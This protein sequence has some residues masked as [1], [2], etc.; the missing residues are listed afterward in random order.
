MASVRAA[1]C[2]LVIRNIHPGLGLRLLRRSLEHAYAAQLTSVPRHLAAWELLVAHARSSRSTIELVPLIA[3]ALRAPLPDDDALYLARLGLEIAW[4]DAGDMVAAQPF[5]AAVLDRAPSQPLATKFVTEALPLA[6]P[7]PPEPELP[8]ELTVSITFRA[9]SRPSPRA[10]PVATVPVEREAVELATDEPEPLTLATDEPEPR[11]PESTTPRPA[12]ATPV[13]GKPVA[14]KPVAGKPFAG[15]PIAGKPV[16]PGRPLRAPPAARATPAAAPQK[17]TPALRRNAS[18]I[19]TTVPP[20]FTGPERAPRKVVPVDVV[21]ELPSGA[22]FST[23]LR[24]LST[25]GAFVM[26]KRDLEVGTTVVLD[27]Q[28]PRSKT[29]AQASYRIDARIARR[30]DLGC[31]LAFVDPPPEFVAALAELTR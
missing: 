15:K 30:S 21:V 14:G 6:P 8:E 22:F 2:E 9:P 31:G 12:A 19:P 16:M 10:E 29:L 3:D 26:T 23:V 1:A 25:T 20:P 7:A 4:R 18:P 27:L 11:A 17:P 28:L 13:A 24:D 5:A